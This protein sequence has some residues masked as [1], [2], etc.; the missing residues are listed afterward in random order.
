[1][2]ISTIGKVLAVSLCSLV[3]QPASTQTLGDV[4]DAFAREAQR[5]DRRKAQ[6]ENEQQIRWLVISSRSEAS[7]A[8][9]IAQSFSMLLGPTMVAQSQN[10][11]FAVAS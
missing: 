3:A 2:R 8:V 7:E 11:S 5:T 6:R 9:S 10:G 4:I 1:M